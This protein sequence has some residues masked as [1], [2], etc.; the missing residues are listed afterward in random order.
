M[1]F[2]AFFTFLVLYSLF[3][4]V[5]NTF[6]NLRFFV[7][8]RGLRKNSHEK[9]VCDLLKAVDSQAKTK[10]KRFQILILNVEFIVNCFT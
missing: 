4:N 9:L 7:Y 3:L 2:I 8:K 6:N 5:T 10:T 1:L